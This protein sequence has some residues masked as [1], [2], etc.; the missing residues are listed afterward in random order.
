MSPHTFDRHEDNLSSAQLLRIEKLHEERDLS[1]LAGARAI[2]ST[3]N[4]LLSAICDYE[5]T[6]LLDSLC[7]LERITTDEQLCD[8]ARSFRAK[9]HLFSLTVADGS[10][11]PVSGDAI[12]DAIAGE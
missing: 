10:T 6:E 3:S 2:R 9:L 11:A 7:E 8:W 4:E 1:V 12:Q 5:P